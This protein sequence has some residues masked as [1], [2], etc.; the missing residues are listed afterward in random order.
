M[1]TILNMGKSVLEAKIS[2]SVKMLIN[3]DNIEHWCKEMEVDLGKFQELSP[4][5]S[6]YLS[7]VD[8]K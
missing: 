4:M 3:V 7:K 8:P 2:R 1:L 5:S 6:M